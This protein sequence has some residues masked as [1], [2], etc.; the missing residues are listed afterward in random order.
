MVSRKSGDTPANSTRYSVS[1]VSESGFHSFGGRN[2]GLAATF[3][4]AR[5]P[6]PRPSHPRTAGGYVLPQPYT[7]SLRRRVASSSSRSTVGVVPAMASTPE[8]NLWAR[9]RCSHFGTARLRAS[10]KRQRSVK[11][12]WDGRER[13]ELSRNSNLCAPRQ[14]VEDLKIAFQI[15]AEAPNRAGQ[16]VVAVLASEGEV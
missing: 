15:E 7:G 13:Y 16:L 12:G 5:G 14:R 2:A 8:K 3:R 9:A 11:G 1:A 10:K 4:L 6:F